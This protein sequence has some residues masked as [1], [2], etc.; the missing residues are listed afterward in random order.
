MARI[1]AERQPQIAAGRGFP[2][3]PSKPV[4]TNGE[5]P[6]QPRTSLPRREAGSSALGRQ[7]SEKSQ[8]VTDI[9]FG[10]HSFETL[11]DWG[12]PLTLVKEW[13]LSILANKIPTGFSSLDAFIDACLEVIADKNQRFYSDGTRGDLG[14]KRGSRRG[15]KR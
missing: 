6:D 10:G 2:L 14:L 9:V 5:N 4:G 7:L 12:F 8:Q 3:S 1:S 13:R 11:K 15:N